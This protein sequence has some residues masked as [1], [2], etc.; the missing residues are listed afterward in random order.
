MFFDIADDLPESF[1]SGVIT[2]GNFDGVHRGHSRLLAR[3]RH[4]ARKL[5]VP[6]IVVTFDPPPLRVLRPESAPPSLLW[7]ERKAEL[8]RAGGADAVLFFRTTPKLLSLTAEEFF[9]EIVIRKLAAKGMVEGPN[10]GFGKDRTGTIEKLVQWCATDNV[11]LD[12]V[13]AL[14][15]DSI[16]VSSTRIRTALI[17]GDVAFARQLLGRPHVI[18][19]TVIQGDGR[20]RQLGFPTANLSDIPN[21]IP[22]EGVYAVAATVNGVDYAGACNVGPNPTFAVQQHKVEV[23][24]LDFTGDIYGR[25]LEVDFLERVR[26]VATFA[27]VEQLIEQVHKDIVKIRAIAA[28]GLLDTAIPAA[29][30]VPCAPELER[31]IAEW[32]RQEIEPA[33]V[34]THTYLKA[35][36]LSAD[37]E[38]EVEWNFPVTIPAMDVMYLLMGSEEQLVSVFKEVAAVKA[39]ASMRPE[40]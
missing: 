37:G 35:L 3:L 22:R 23:H 20:G 15:T 2:I 36:K 6:G 19:G 5:G 26:D 32:I 10:F 30:R 39:S 31:T 25:T 24:L 1:R 14:E 16:A 33:L 29:A 4:R 34:S 7:P 38:L 11:P 8:L 28:P 27:G 13:T 21:L 9:R 12:I 40:P 18:R 17:E